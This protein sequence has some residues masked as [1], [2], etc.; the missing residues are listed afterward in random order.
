[1]MAKTKA[2]KMRM[3]ME[4]EGRRNPELN[5]QTWDGFNPLERKPARPKIEQRRKERK[6]KRNYIDDRNGGYNYA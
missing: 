4:R 5:R 1:M 6:Y 2:K 3:K